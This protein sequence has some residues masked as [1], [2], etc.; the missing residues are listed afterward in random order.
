MHLG[1][2]YNGALGPVLSQLRAE[3]LTRL[4]IGLPKCG[5]ASNLVS[6]GDARALPSLTWLKVKSQLSLRLQLHPWKPKAL[7]VE[8]LSDVD[9]IFNSNCIFE[10]EISLAK[11]VQT[12]RFWWDP[13]DADELDETPSSVRALI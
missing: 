13:H 2:K 1:S 8:A 11:F 4:I 6:L 3:K 10:H 5:T 12:I 7:D 9:L